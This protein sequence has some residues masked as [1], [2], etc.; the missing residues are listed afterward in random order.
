MGLFQK[1]FLNMYRVWFCITPERVWN[2][3]IRVWISLPSRLIFAAITYEILMVFIWASKFYK[4]HVK[5]L[6]MRLYRMTWF[7]C[8][9]TMT[10]HTVSSNRVIGRD[11][12]VL[13]FWM[14]RLIFFGSRLKLNFQVWNYVTITFQFPLFFPPRVW[15]FIENFAF[16]S[17]KPAQL[18]PLP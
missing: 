6:L 15:N 8:L 9:K 12:R 18:N 7:T 2:F 11:P 14:L 4:N 3:R 17:A 10:P 1:W 13:F 5:I 16:T